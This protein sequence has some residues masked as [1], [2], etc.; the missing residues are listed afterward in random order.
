M[1]SHVQRRVAASDGRRSPPFTSI[2]G[3]QEQGYFAEG[4]VEETTSALSLGHWLV[5]IALNS[6]FTYNGRIVD[7]KQVGRELGVRYVL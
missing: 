6:S 5:V 7:V 3:D 1:W 4:I 2:C